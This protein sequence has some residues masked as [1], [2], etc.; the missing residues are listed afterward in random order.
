MKTIELSGDIGWEITAKG[1]RSQLIMNS[2]EPVRVKINSYGGDV[3]EAFQ[4]YNLFHDYPGEIILAVTGIAASAAA[5][6]AM[7]ADKLELYKNSS[8]M[9]HRAWS[10]FWGNAVEFEREAKLLADIDEIQ[11]S[12]YA[13]KTGKTRAAA[14]AEFTNE[15]WLIGSEKIAAAGIPFTLIDGSEDDEPAN[16]KEVN[17]KIA[18][19]VARMKARAPQNSGIDMSILNKYQDKPQEGNMKQSFAD[20]MK[21]N[22]EAKADVLAFAEKEKPP[23]PAA[24]AAA[25]VAT[26]LADGVRVSEILAL[27]GVVLSAEIKAAIADPKITP[28]KFAYEAMKKNT[29]ALAKPNAAAL[30]SPAASAQTPGAQSAAL[31]DKTTTDPD[32]VTDEEELRKLAKKVNGGK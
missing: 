31:S 24:L 3:F 6:L 27:A 5:Y 22:P 4:I 8:L 19:I 23:A 20:F 10:I 16:E 1:I 26:D 30:G 7:G 11:A 14:L 32:A 18:A 29:A 17:E 28:E 21:E 12:D 25:V 9:F 15:V 2:R 13:K